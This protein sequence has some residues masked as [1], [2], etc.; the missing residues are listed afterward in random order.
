[1]SKFYFTYGIEGQPFVGG[2]TEIEAPDGAIAAELFRAVH[3]DKT[4][5]ILNCAWVYSEEQFKQTEMA[6][7]NGNFGY[8]CHEKITVTRTSTN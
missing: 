7:P 4:P 3:P 6:D 2:W 1:M 5:G 8:F